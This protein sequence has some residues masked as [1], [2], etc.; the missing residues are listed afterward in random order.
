MHFMPPDTEQIVGDWDCAMLVRGEDR[1]GNFEPT[2][3]PASD[4]DPAAVAFHKKA[5]K[6]FNEVLYKGAALN[7]AKL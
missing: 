1:F 6:A 2:P 7:D 5:S 3:V 4:F